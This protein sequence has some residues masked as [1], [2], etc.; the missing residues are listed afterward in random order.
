MR[1][2]PAE[3]IAVPE[4]L[5]L[6]G[7]RFAVPRH[8]VMDDLDPVVARAFERALKALV[9]QGREGRADRPAAAQRA[10][11]DQRQGRV[12]RVGGLCLARTLIAR[13][14]KDYDPLVDAA[15]LRGK[16]MSAADYIEPV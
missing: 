7:L 9:G 14:G 11:G 16:E 5:P 1:C 2:S 6:A 12:R 13:R 4:P 8:F 3:P 10:A 15:H